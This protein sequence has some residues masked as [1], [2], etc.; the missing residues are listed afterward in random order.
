MVNINYYFKMGLRYILSHFKN[1]IYFKYKYR[2][3]FLGRNVLLKGNVKLDNDVIIFDNSKIFGNCKLSKKVRVSENVEIRTTYTEI[4]IGEGTTVNRNSMII[5]KIN[6]GKYCLI[7]P[8]VVIV[9]SNHN[10]DDKNE[11]IRKQGVSSRGITIG[12]DVWIGANATI[13]DGVNIGKGA[14]IA[15]GAV[16]TKN[17]EEYTIVGGVPAKFISKR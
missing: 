13:T 4:F 1:L 16:V 2:K 14:I 7:A 12:D 6:I 5:G 11:L 8:N 3:L 10:F 9:G 17:V 15:A